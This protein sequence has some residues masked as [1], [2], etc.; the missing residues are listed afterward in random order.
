MRIGDGRLV[1][2]TL[3]RARTRPRPERAH[4]EQTIAHEPTKPECPLVV[5]RI[6]RPRFGTPSHC[7]DGWMV[8]RKGMAMPFAFANRPMIEERREQGWAA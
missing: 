5:L 4:V 3:S 2:L 1:R 6:E 7:L 8:R